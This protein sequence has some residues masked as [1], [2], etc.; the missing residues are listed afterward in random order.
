MRKSTLPWGLFRSGDDRHPWVAKEF[1][2]EFGSYAVFV[3][4]RDTAADAVRLEAAIGG[5]RAAQPANSLYEGAAADA[6]AEAL[7]EFPWSAR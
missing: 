2:A 7:G 4:G 5:A 1:V 3:V 6:E